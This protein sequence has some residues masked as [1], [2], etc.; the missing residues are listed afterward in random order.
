[1]EN[2]FTCSKGHIAGADDRTRTGNLLITSQPLCQLS[3]VGLL[4]FLMSH[5]FLVLPT[6]LATE[7]PSVNVSGEFP[8]GAK[9]SRTKGP[10]LGP[11]S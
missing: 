11:S 1:M 4:S 7:G 9:T 2:S 10:Y 5:S 3:Y 6:I 8:S